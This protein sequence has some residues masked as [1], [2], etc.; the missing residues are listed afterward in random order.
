MAYDIFIEASE[1][2]RHC[3]NNLGMK[4]DRGAKCMEELVTFV[5]WGGK[6]V[7]IEEESVVTMG[8]NKHSLSSFLDGFIEVFI[9]HG[10]VV[11]G[12]KREIIVVI[13]GGSCTSQWFPD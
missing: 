3:I 8:L 11:H 7:L 6:I 4:I 10:A 9:W 5:N 12:N 13:V 1:H 2:I